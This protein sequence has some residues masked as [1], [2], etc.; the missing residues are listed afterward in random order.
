MMNYLG[1]INRKMSIALH[2][3]VRKTRRAVPF[4]GRHFRFRM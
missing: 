1:M 4:K 2:R 3:Q